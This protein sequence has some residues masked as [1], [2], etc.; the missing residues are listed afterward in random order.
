MRFSDRKRHMRKPTVLGSVVCLALLLSALGSASG[1]IVP[2]RPS[3]QS[4][5]FRTPGAQ[6]VPVLAGEVMLGQ[7]RLPAPKGPASF[8]LPSPY[9]VPD[10]QRLFRLETEAELFRRM[11]RESEQGI[12]PLNLK[13]ETQ[14]P[15]YPPTPK[16]VSLTRN[17]PVLTEVA[18]PPYV[19]YRRL[20]FEQINLERYGWDFCLL[21]PFLA[22][23]KFYFDLVTLP[24]HAGTDLFRR[25]ECNSGYPLPG[26]PV[27]FM[28]YKPELSL[29]GAAF[30]VAKVGCILV[31]FP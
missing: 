5:A 15:V 24:Y 11:S 22:Q 31:T 17:W 23:G 10:S 29:T 18:E 6:W 12:N 8:A 9:E 28:I 30:E 2:G 4:V 26:D 13:Y 1:Q 16:E 19:C 25:Y 7:E 20:Y 3:E 27:P 21:T 14:F